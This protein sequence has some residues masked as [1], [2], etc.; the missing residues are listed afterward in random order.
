MEPMSKTDLA[1]G[2]KMNFRQLE[3]YLKELCEKDLVTEVVIDN[4][5]RYI[6]TPAGEEALHDIEKV[7]E[8]LDE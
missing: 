5:K 7:M 8:Q 2:T 4:R 3:G 6:I 1:Y